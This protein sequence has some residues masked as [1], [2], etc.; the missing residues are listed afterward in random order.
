M[1]LVRR[2]FGFLVA[3][4]LTPDDQL[5]VRS[6]LSDE[7]RRHFY[8]QR[9]EDQR[10]AFD[11]MNR[12]SQQQEL[13]EAALMHDIGKTEADLG[14]T[15]RALATVWNSVGLPLTA[16][17]QM[18]IEHGTR[19]ARAIEGLHADPLT[20]AFMLHHPGAVPEGIEP[21]AWRDL[22]EADDA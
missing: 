5:A 20:V 4:P 17:W 10:H 21:A 6:S 22:T 18:Y 14:A 3:R 8:W 11:V 15:S 7:L 19:G 12:V 13:R 9:S 16:R 2:F 1:H